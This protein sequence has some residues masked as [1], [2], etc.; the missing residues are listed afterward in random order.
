MS[1]SRSSTLAQMLDDTVAAL[2]LETS[3]LPSEELH[4]AL[5]RLAGMGPFT[6]ANMLELLGRFDRIP[7]DTET[8]RHLAKAHGRSGLT[9]K[10]LQETAQKVLGHARPHLINAWLRDA[11][12][13]PLHAAAS[14]GHVPQITLQ[15]PL[16]VY[17]KYHPYEF[18]AYWYE[19]RR[20]YDA[21]F[22][23]LVDMDPADY[24]KA[25]GAYLL[26]FFRPCAMPKGIALRD[27][28]CSGRPPHAGARRQ[29]RCSERS[30]GAS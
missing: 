6:A 10:N 4:R 30:K 22:G 13:S 14:G 21:L 7:A 8:A 9:A 28:A 11:Q 24:A 18:L 16:Q 12:D 5:L 3:A 15:C 19:I 25:T 29:D 26:A 1:N 27:A 20:D 17:S 2:E 23:S